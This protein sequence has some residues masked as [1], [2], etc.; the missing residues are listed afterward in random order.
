[1][2][3]ADEKLREFE[4]VKGPAE[5]KLLLK[6]AARTTAST[7]LWTKDQKHSINTHITYFN[8]ED[9]NISCWIPGG[10]DPAKFMDDLA[11]M[12]SKD[13][14]FSVSLQQANVFF[15]AEYK[16]FDKGGMKFFLPE[17]VFKVQR[18]KDFRAKIP[19]SAKLMMEFEDPADNESRTS[20]RIMDLSAGG[21]A[22]FVEEGQED[23]YRVRTVLKHVRFELA[24][25]RVSCETEIRHLRRVTGEKKKGFKIGL[26]FLGIKAGD[27]Q[28]IASF[29]FEESRKH[30]ARLI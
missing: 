16:G 18:R 15:K 1:L 25:R 6:E 22:I 24:G 27:A 30:F 29:V 14:Y 10:F 4:P 2:S 3:D 9:R 28:A 19:E 23:A 8:E 13:C 26:L 7:I 21:A 17:K 20:K 12:K 11:K 5:A